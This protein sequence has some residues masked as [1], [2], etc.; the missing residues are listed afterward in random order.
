M[1]RIRLGDNCS[2]NAKSVEWMQVFDVVSRSVNE[3]RESIAGEPASGGSEVFLTHALAP[4]HFFAGSQ[5]C[6]YFRLRSVAQCVIHD[7][8][9]CLRLQQAEGPEDAH[10]LFWG[11]AT[12]YVR[13]CH[14]IERCTLIAKDLLSLHDRNVVQSGGINVRERIEEGQSVTCVFDVL[15]DDTLYAMPSAAVFQQTECLCTAVM[16]TDQL[17]RES[18]LSI[19][20]FLVSRRCAQV[21]STC[22]QRFCHSARQ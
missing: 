11:D 10:A 15:E 17:F 12:E 1:K 21:R 9:L 6:E 7:E 3:L 4:F 13:E 22:C 14:N 20:G 8:Q 2:T 5:Q 16:C 18:L 19:I